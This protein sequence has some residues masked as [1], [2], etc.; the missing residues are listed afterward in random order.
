[1]KITAYD[2]TIFE[3]VIRELSERGDEEGSDKLQFLLD[4]HDRLD[5]QAQGSKVCLCPMVFNGPLFPPSKKPFEI[6]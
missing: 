5:Y 4:E 2:R 6:Q 3:R 1:M